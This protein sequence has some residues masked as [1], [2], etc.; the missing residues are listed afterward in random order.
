MRR[1]LAIV[2]CGALV[3]G[4]TGCSAA[5]DPKPTAT[6][7]IAVAVAA[8]LPKKG[9]AAKALR[10]PLASSDLAFGID[11]FKQLRAA[12]K[13]N[14]MVSP[15]SV[16]SA[17]AMTANGA[18]GK[19]RTEMERVLRIDGLGRDK[20]NQAYADLTAAL[21]KA[22]A[23]GTLA[24]ANSLW[25]DDGLKLKASFLAR[26]RDFFGAGVSSVP[27][28]DPP[29]AMKAINDWVSGKTNGKIPKLLSSIPQATIIALV[30]A[31]YFKQ[32]WADPFDAALTKPQPF[33]LGDGSKADV[34]MMHRGGEMDYLETSAFQAVKLPYKGDAAM[35]VFLPKPGNDL[36]AIESPLSPAE[37][38]GWMSAFAQ[39]PGQLALPR[40]TLRTKSEL[41]RPL[42]NMG[43]TSA[44]DNAD[45]SDMTDAGA[46]ISQVVHSV[47]VSVDESGT[48]AA[49]ASAAMMVS[50]AS[51]APANPFLMTVDRPFFFAIRD[52]P[53]GEVL[54]MGSVTDP[55]GQ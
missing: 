22:S 4:T 50:G 42:E 8:E 39:R 33:T 21:V 32:Q 16:A 36:A 37:W 35:Y 3:A 1:I 20:A 19:T 43:M 23:D 17:L 9:V 40:F 45:F 55:R 38:D 44:F 31:V 12:E 46:F 41:S 52:E 51:P 2:V 5:P 7:G 54:F 48:E 24:V 34:P 53:T 28:G 29:V 27:F 15:L 14:L 10:S 30:N 47:Y 26:D 25:V 11:L 13:G 49:A 6:G 18:A